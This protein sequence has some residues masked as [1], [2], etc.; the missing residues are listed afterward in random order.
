M[1]AF[2]F[3]MI[4][5]LAT[6]DDPIQSD[7]TETANQPDTSITVGYEIDLS[8]V[9]NQPREIIYDF[10]NEHKFALD[11]NYD[12][13]QVEN[14][15]KLAD[16]RAHY[17]LKTVVFLKDVTL[18]MTDIPFIIQFQSNIFTGFIPVNPLISFG[19]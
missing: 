12:S 2:S 5:G 19:F 16:M 10:L 7:S 14:R 11:Y 8:I 1:F 18:R 6:A 9:A 15:D 13:I 17:A 3:I 4:T